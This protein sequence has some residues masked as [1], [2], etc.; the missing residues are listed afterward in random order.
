[1]FKT[2]TL[3]FLHA[4]LRAGAGFNRHILEYLANPHTGHYKS[5]ANAKLANTLWYDISNSVITFMNS[6]SPAVVVCPPGP[7][8]DTVATG[9][10]RR[11]RRHETHSNV[12]A[13]CFDC[14]GSEARIRI[15]ATKR[16]KYGDEILLKGYL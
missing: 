6:A 12:S 16:I 1:M 3:S 4:T 8:A 2:S 14:D 15:Q 11:S 5:L 9:H 10:P 13:E 7:E